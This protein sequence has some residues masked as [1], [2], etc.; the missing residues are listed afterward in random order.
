FALAAVRRD[1]A[2]IRKGWLPILVLGLL[3]VGAFNALLYQ[4]LRYT[5]A[6]NALLLQAAIPTMVVLFDR[7]IFGVR[8][9]RVQLAATALSTLGVLA[10]VFQGDPT[11]A[12][13]LRFGMGDVLILAAVTAWALYTVLLRLRPPIAPISFIFVTFL[14]GVLA[15]APLTLW[16][17]LSGPWVNW[18]PLAFAA[19]G[20][21]ALLP[22]LAAYFM[23]NFATGTLGPARAGQAITLMPLFG[24]LASAL[25]LGERLEGYHFAGMALIV[26]GIAIAML[27]SA[28]KSPLAPT[29]AGG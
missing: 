19:I 27:G 4:G 17:A 2:A 3:G 10:I 21:V 18:T 12:A 23:F 5:P 25:I 16:E 26:S 7:L 6:T 20:Y 13:R 29:A 8:A 15:M 1:V 9:G 22:S 24:A 11:A 28:G 14:I